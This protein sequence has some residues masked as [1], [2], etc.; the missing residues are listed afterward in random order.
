[1]KLATSLCE[2]SRLKTP[3][4]GDIINEA[5][6]DFKFQAFVN[7]LFV[8]ISLGIDPAVDQPSEKQRATTRITMRYKEL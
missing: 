6:E 7:Q 4:A 2:N 8:L 1:M 5:S 3:D